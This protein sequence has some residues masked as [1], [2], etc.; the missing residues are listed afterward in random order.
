[1]PAASRC[2]CGISATPTQSPE[3]PVPLPTDLTPMRWFWDYSHYRRAAGDLILDR[4]FGHSE[5]SRTLP[6]DFGVRLTAE[7]VDAHLARSKT[8]LTDWAATNP[9]LAS[10][11]VAAAQNPKAQTRQAEAT[12]W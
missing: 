3:K 12:C 11:I 9:E 5:P 6:A 1:M 4:V 7:N 10:Q 2:R 8:K